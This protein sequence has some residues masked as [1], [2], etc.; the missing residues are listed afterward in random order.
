[1]K[2]RIIVVR[3]RQSK[4]DGRSQ[5]KENEKFCVICNEFRLQ[6]KIRENANVDIQIR[7]KNKKKRTKIALQSCLPKGVLRYLLICVKNMKIMMYELF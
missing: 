1:M 3:L 2:D 4:T 5:L 6:R 7:E